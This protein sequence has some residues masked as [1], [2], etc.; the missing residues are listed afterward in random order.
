MIS[1]ATHGATGDGET[2]DRAAILTAIAALSTTDRELFFPPGR[3]KVS[4]YVPISGVD[5]LLIRGQ[6]ATILHQSADTGIS[7]DATA[8]SNAMA[9]AGLLAIDC[10]DLV[11]RDLQFEGDSAQVDINVNVGVGV[12][13]RNCLRARLENLRNWYGGALLNQDNQSGDVGLRLVGSGSYGARGNVTTGSDAVIEGCRFELPTDSGYHRSG[14]NGSSHAVYLFGGR[15][16]VRIAGCTFRNIRK[17][18]VKG[19]GSASPLRDLS[20]SGCVFIDCGNGVLWGAD[21]AQEHTGLLIEGCTFVDCGTNITGW[22]DGAAITVYGSDATI[23]R[24]NVIRY[25]RACLGT[26]A[27]VKGIQV[28]TYPSGRQCRGVLVAGNLLVAD[29]GL[30]APDSIVTHGIYAYDVDDLAI[31]DNAII[32]VSGLALFLYDTPRAVVSGMDISNAV[33]A[34]RLELSPGCTFR[35]VAIKRGA[36][37]ST[38]PLIVQV[39]SPNLAQEDS[40]VIASDGSRSKL[41]V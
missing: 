32:N 19:S 33:T 11:I 29:V 30:T 5:G 38:N 14:N 25:T 37:T 4:K 7:T 8:T 15:T 17:S 18:G 28:Q 2:D 10:D 20:V 34:G 3:Y 39:T 12:Y 16:N 6:G 40:Y 41:I 21:D 22:T 23:I 24:G 1:V 36:Q 27:A 26:V 31:R 9:R 13:L 35:N